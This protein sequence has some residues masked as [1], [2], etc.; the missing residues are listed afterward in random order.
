M[1]KKR[2]FLPFEEARAVV[3]E[4]NINSV[5]DWEKLSTDIK[6]SLGV[7]ACSALYYKNK[8]WTNWVDFLGITPRHKTFKEARAIAQTLGIKSSYE[9]FGSK[10]HLHKGL[11]I[12]NNPLFYYKNKGWVNWNDFLGVQKKA[13]YKSFWEA[14]E[15]AQTLGI[16]SSYEWIRTKSHLR[17]NIGLPSGPHNYYKNMGWAGWDDFLGMV[18]QS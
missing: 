2:D 14:K 11:G 3:R 7:P 1:R 4:L 6:H 17:K 18:K 10:C 15:I 16:K 12:P 5:K 9:W 8:G 13:P